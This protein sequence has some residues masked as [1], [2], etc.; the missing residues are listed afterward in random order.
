M[1]PDHNR[2]RA[3]TLIGSNLGGR[4]PDIQ[5]QAIFATDCFTVKRRVDIKQWSSQ[6]GAHITE[7]GGGEYFVERLEGSRRFPT[8]FADWRLRV[9][10]SA[11][12]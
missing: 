3:R 2:E 12:A 4:S 9:R 10:D 7:L 8:Q 1:D 6:L 11:P 5:S